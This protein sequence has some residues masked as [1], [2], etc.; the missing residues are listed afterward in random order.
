MKSRYL[1]NLPKNKKLILF[2]VMGAASD[3][4]KGFNQLSEFF[5][6][7]VRDDIEFVVFGAS[8]PIKPPDLGCKTHCW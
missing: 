1:W 6:N 8:T 4:R 7:I 3:P 2:G 5:K